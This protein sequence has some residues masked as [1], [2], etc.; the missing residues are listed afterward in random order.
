MIEM[1]RSIP[2]CLNAVRASGCKQPYS[3]LTKTLHFL[4]PDTFPIFDSQAAKSLWMWNLF[5]GQDVLRVDDIA[6]GGGVGYS[7]LMG[8]YR[9]VWWSADNELRNAAR[10]AAKGLQQLLN[11]NGTARVTVL[12]LID[13]LLWHA[14]GNPLMLGLAQPPC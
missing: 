2:D 10:G 14:D 8:V 6:S 13:K 3:L 9:L 7:E 12:D 5:A 1:A 11:Q 4:F